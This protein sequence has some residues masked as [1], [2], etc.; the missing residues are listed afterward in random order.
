MSLYKEIKDFMENSIPIL[1]NIEKPYFFSCSDLLNQMH[2]DIVFRGLNKK[3]LHSCT[4][5]K[6]NN[7]VEIN[8]SQIINN[9][10]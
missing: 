6:F 4:K 9:S 8:G 7:N 2:K 5:R 10:L 3:V 1:M